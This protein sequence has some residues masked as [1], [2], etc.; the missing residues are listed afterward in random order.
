MLLVPWTILPLRM[1]DWALKAPTAEI[2]ITCYAVFMV[3][4]G[5]FTFVSYTGGN[6]RNNLMR[7]CVVVNSLYFVFGVFVLGLIYLPKI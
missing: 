5:I 6:V 2:M 7:I 4:S 3:F 1:F